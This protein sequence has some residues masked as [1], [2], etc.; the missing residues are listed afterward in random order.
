MAKKSNGGD[1]PK[2]YEKSIRIEANGYFLNFT[3]GLYQEPMQEDM[4]DEVTGK[5]GVIVNIRPV[6]IG[7]ILARP[8]AEGLGIVPEKK[9]TCAMLGGKLF[10]HAQLEGKEGHFAVSAEQLTLIKTVVENIKFK[11]QQ[12]NDK[13]I[14][15]LI[16]SLLFVLDP[17]SANSD[18][19]AK[20]YLKGKYSKLDELV[21]EFESTSGSDDNPKVNK[22]EDGSPLN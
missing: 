19:D 15:W 8:V 21:L 9:F 14:P 13:S 16:A 1:S 3:G 5:K 18:P 20:E 11:D 2:V 6:K 17:E 4:V 22:K 7:E 12:G 10:D